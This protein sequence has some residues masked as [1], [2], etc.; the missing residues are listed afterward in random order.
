M[1]PN[2][3]FA[4]LSLSFRK[5]RFPENSLFPFLTF[6]PLF[7]GLWG[8]GARKGTVFL[9]AS[10]PPNWGMASLPPFLNKQT[11]RGFLFCVFQNL[12]L[13]EIAQVAFLLLC[14]QLFCSMG[15]DNTGPQTGRPDVEHFSFFFLSKSV[16]L[17]RSS[18]NSSF[19]PPLTFGGGV[20]VGGLHSL[21]IHRPL[22]GQQK[23]TNKKNSFFGSFSAFFPCLLAGVVLFPQPFT[24]GQQFEIPF[25]RIYIWYVFSI[26]NNSPFFARPSGYLIVGGADGELL[27][28]SGFPGAPLPVCSQA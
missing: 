18:T 9:P 19:P 7:T 26:T 17:K 3:A 16:G 21:E 20:W 6:S 25:F 22:Y 23:K 1:A 11:G 5:V 8:R 10:P 13:Q 28:A 27:R 15:T 14:Q 24:K 4:P 2:V 12:G